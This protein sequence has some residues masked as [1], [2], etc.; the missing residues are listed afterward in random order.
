MMT[1]DD[2]SVTVKRQEERTVPIQERMEKA[3]ANVVEIWRKET[4]A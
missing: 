3:M 2:T 1:G 4:A